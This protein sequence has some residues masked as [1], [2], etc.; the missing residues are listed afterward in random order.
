LKI[1]GAP[2]FVA[3]V[4]F[5]LPYLMLSTD[6]YV[7]TF[8]EFKNGIVES[9]GSII[10]YEQAAN[11]YSHNKSFFTGIVEK[12]GTGNFTYPIGKQNVYAPL[13]IDKGSSESVYTEY[14]IG[15]TDKL[16][17]HLIKAPKIIEINPKEYW[18]I[19]VTNNKVNIIELS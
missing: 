17:S 5:N 9:V 12:V 8:S 7:D 19:Q 13:V 6:L 1:T 18:N 2:L 4:E 16:L 14:L 3:S 10:S 11:S 15:D